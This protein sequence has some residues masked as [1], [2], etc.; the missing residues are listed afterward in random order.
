MT[1]EK[2]IRE[3]NQHNFTTTKDK[4]LTKCVVKRLYV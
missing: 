2:I 4:L 1:A 3:L